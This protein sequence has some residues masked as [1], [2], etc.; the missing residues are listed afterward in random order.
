LS[1]LGQ[2]G[3]D[4]GMAVLKEMNKLEAV[5]DAFVKSLAPRV[6]VH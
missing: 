2:V 4:Q 5:H 1:D 3:G 6:D